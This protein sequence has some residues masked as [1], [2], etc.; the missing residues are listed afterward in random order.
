MKKESIHD[1][2]FL[3]LLTALVAVSTMVISIPVPATKGY[4][5][6]G[7]SMIFL[8]AI[9]FGRKKG[10][11]AAGVGSAMADMF[12]GYTHWAIP[13]L[14][15]KGIMGYGVGLIA[16]QEDEKLINVRNIAA[17]IIGALWMVIGYLLAGTMIIGSFEVALTELPANLIQSFGGAILFV[18]IGIALKKTKYFSKYVLK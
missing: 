7:D 8:T 14:I 5:H 13:T 11:V 12:L 9:M 10:A 2:A 3:G 16:H 1:L 17:L 18:P 6:L 15:I 4:I